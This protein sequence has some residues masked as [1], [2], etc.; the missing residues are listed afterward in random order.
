MVCLWF[1]GVFCLIVGLALDDR[2]RDGLVGDE[3]D[4]VLEDHDLGYTRAGEHG[5]AC[6]VVCD[7]PQKTQERLIL[8]GARPQ[9]PSP[10]RPVGPSGSNGSPLWA[11]TRRLK[12]LARSFVVLSDLREEPRNQTWLQRWEH[13]RRHGALLARASPG[14]NPGAGKR[15]PFS[16]VLRDTVP[17]PVLIER[18]SCPAIFI[19][20]FIVTAVLLSSL[21][22]TAVRTSRG[23]HGTLP[24]LAAIIFMI[25]LYDTHPQ[26]RKL[27]LFGSV[28]GSRGAGS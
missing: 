5:F 7:T 26:P 9:R 3:V 17:I 24:E 22:V 10:R 16:S 14:S 18:M 20:R 19:R 12:P 11:Y 6:A 28:G 13:R 27:A 2:R 1:V 23:V 8:A 25:P 21:V 4:V 15:S